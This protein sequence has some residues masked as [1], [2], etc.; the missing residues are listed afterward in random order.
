MPN[1]NQA[2]KKIALKKEKLQKNK[3]SQISQSTSQ[4]AL[5]FLEAESP[6]VGKPIDEPL[7]KE[8][9]RATAAK[10]YYPAKAAAFHIK[11]KVTIRFLLQ[12]D[13]RVEEARVVESSGFSVLDEAALNT[14]R[15]ISPVR[16]ANLYLTKA[17]YIHAGIL[18]G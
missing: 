10:L 14:I 17:R 5:P 7:L 1:E 6:N 9:T 18:F 13:G 16:D 12:P 11:G 4:G 2:L 8:L 15:S 3:V